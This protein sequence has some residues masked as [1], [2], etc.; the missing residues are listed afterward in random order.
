MVKFCSM[1]FSEESNIITM[2][3]YY[4]IYK[5]TFFPNIMIATITVAPHLPQ[6]DQI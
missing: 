1:G 2:A 3:W 5:S 4:L 6:W